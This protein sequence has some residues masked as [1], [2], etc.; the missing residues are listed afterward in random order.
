MTTVEL[1]DGRFLEYVA[2]EAADGLPLVIHHGT[3]SGAVLYGD[4]VASTRAAGFRAILPARAGYGQSSPRPGR[5]VADVAGDVAALLDAL[6]VGEF[7]TVGWSGGG[8]HSMACAALLPGRCLAAATI[9]GVA[10]YDAAGLDWMGGMGT[11]NVE[12]FGAAVAG[13]AELTTYLEAAA[14]AL[15]H[16]GPG[17]L[18]AALGDLVSD[19]DKQTLTGEFAEYMLASFRSALAN[20]VAGWRDDDLAFVTGWGFGLADFRVPVAIWQGDQDRMV[21]FDHGRWF[22]DN[23]PGARIHLVPGEGHLSLHTRGLTAVLTDLAAAAA[24]Q[25][26]PDKV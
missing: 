26:R 23:V 10:P 11:E 16:A 2:D 19:V 17:D 15:E 4:M 14:A 8:P 7:A 18:V 13:P 22:A 1:P 3:P 5:L 9:A 25:V 12:E 24:G 20:G 21:P 6:G